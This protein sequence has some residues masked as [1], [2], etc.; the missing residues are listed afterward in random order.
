LKGLTCEDLS[1]HIHGTQ[2]HVERHVTLNDG[3]LALLAL[4]DLKHLDG[5]M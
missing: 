4:V 5:L 1:H 2:R 3:V